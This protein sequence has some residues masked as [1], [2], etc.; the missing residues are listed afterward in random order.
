MF[1]DEVSLLSVLSWIESH[2]VTVGIGTAVAA[3][4][5]GL[6][7][8]LGQR[9]EVDIFGLYA[10]LMFLIKNL[11]IRLDDKK[12]LE[13][14]ERDKG[15]IYTLLYNSDTRWDLCLGFHVPS[16]KELE[17]IKKLASKLEK[18]LT[19]SHNNVYPRTSSRE[20]WYKQQQVLFDFCKFIKDKSMQGYMSKAEDEEP[21]HIKE[22][23]KLI[24][25]MNYIQKAIEEELG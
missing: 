20:V 3:G 21:E 1:L 25:A 19:G 9:R 2:P 5:F 7:K 12:L 14:E 24:K 22:C 11:R 23:T 16:D 10:R 6:Y 17:D 8:F 15:N 18:V 13:I 4:A